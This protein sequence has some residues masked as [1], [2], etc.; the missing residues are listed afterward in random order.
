MRQRGPGQEGIPR[1]GRISCEGCKSTGVQ[2]W[3][4]C[5]GWNVEKYASKNERRKCFDNH[6]GYQLYSGTYFEIKRP[7]WTKIE[8]QVDNSYLAVE[9]DEQARMDHTLTVRSFDPE[10]N[11]FSL[12]SA[13]R[14]LTPE[15]W[16]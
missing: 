8:C 10:R 5:Q 9:A 12:S 6:Y 4:W 16:L 15:V 3:V 14:H 7:L 11:E 1:I 13:R 2:W